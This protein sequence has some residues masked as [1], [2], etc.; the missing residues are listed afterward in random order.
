[1]GDIAKFAEATVGE[2]DTK[3]K[4]VRIP[5]ANLGPCPVCG[6]DIVE[7]RKGYSCWSREDP[8][9]GFVIWKAKAGKQLP[10]AVARELIRTGRTEKAGDRLQGPLRP[11]VPRAARARAER[12]G[13][14][15]RRV[16]RAVGREGAKPPEAEAEAPPDAAR[17]EP[18]RRE[19]SRRRLSPPWAAR[20][21]A[22]V[23]AA[24]AVGVARDHS[25]PRPIGRCSYTRPRS[26]QLRQGRRGPGRLPRARAGGAVLVVPTRADARPLRARAAERRRDLGGRVR[27]A[28]PA[29]CARSRG[30]PATPRALVGPLQRERV[31]AAGDRRGAALRRSRRSPRAGLLAAALRARRPSSSARSSRR[32]ASRRRCG[33]GPAR[34]GRAATPRASRRSTPLRARAR[35]PR[36]ASTPSCFAWRALDALRADP[37]AGAATPVLFYG[38]DDLTALQRDAVETLA[39]ASPAPR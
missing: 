22:V 23:P 13:Q 14:V 12:R 33:P 9:C 6:H 30:A 18:A 2:L 39:G 31:V 7:N 8:G 4:D 27:H 24:G 21:Q 28:S 35:A 37:A 15:A 17:A 16:R 19:Q 3:L 38:F 26:R 1:M 34:P 32:S 25:E 11:L 20:E 29:S 36:A 10:A 5:R